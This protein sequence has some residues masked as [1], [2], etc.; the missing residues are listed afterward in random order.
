MDTNIFVERTASMFRVEGSTVKFLRDTG[1]TYQ[2]TRCHFQED[3][4]M[5]LYLSENLK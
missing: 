1:T 2:A 5:N 4:D 3:H